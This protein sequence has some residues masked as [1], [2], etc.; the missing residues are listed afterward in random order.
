MTICKNTSDP[1]RN[2]EYGKDGY[3]GCCPKTSCLAKIGDKNYFKEKIGIPSEV[4]KVK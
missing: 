2:D 3:T 4:G 1:N